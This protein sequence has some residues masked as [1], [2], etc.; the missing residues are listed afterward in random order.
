[1]QIAFTG[2]NPSGRTPA[3]AYIIRNSSRP[4]P[5]EMA[6]MRQKYRRRSWV[7]RSPP[8]CRTGTAGADSR[9]S[10]ENHSGIRPVK[11]KK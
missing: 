4:I 10:M 2:K 1:M 9:P 6:Q 11:P 8:P 3:L 5:A 7:W